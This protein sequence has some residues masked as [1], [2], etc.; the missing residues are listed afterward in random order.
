M[1]IFVDARIPVVF[2]VEPGEGDVLLVTEADGPAVHPNGCTCCVARSPD[3][4]GFD[5]LFLDRVRGTIPWFRRVV[6]AADHAGLRQAL[7]TDP[8]LTARFRL[9]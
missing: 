6:V 5:R 3:A 2:G 9:G 8:V 1:T 7:Q 4:A